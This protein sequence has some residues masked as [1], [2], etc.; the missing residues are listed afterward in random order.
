MSFAHWDISAITYGQGVFLCQGTGRTRLH[1][2]WGGQRASPYKHPWKRLILLQY[3]LRS[4]TNSS[5][6]WDIKVRV[7]CRHPDIVVYITV[8]SNGPWW[9]QGLGNCARNYKNGVETVPVL[10]SLQPK[11]ASKAGDTGTE[12]VT[13]VLSG[14]L[15]YTS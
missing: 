6:V 9:D 5:T 12:S 11:W 13:L 3:N 4:W 8:V 1:Q 10:K 14:Y 2:E 7:D 15:S